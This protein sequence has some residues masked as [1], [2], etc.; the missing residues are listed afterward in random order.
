MVQKKGFCPTNLYRV[1]KTLLSCLYPTTTTS[2]YIHTHTHKI[3]VSKKSKHSFTPNKLHHLFLPLSY[4]LHR[5]SP[6]NLYFPTQRHY[7][8][9]SPSHRESAIHR[10]NTTKFKLSSQPYN[11]ISY[12]STRERACSYLSITSTA[13][14]PLPTAVLSRISAETVILIK[15]K[16]AR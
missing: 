7:C 14:R 1:I 3:L 9:L 13:R 4:Q 2:L 15:E 11:K 10:Y 12:I 6:T 5:Q 16:I 8:T